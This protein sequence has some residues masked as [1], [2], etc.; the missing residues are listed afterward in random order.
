MSECLVKI[1]GS[2]VLGERRERLLLFCLGVGVVFTH[3]ELDHGINMV[4]HQLGDLPMKLWRET[5]RIDY[6]K[7]KNAVEFA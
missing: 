5:L 7:R 6:L 1:A 4:F 3:G 2:H